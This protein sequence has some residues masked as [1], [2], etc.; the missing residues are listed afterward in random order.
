M[1]QKPKTKKMHSIPLKGKHKKG[2]PKK[3]VQDV[4]CQ[5][6]ETVLVQYWV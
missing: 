6:G 3:K 5:G 1:L 4:N 2:V